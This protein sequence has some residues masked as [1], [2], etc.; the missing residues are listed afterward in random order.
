MRLLKV[1]HVLAGYGKKDII[2]DV[3]MQVERGQM[4]GI[5]GPN[6]CGK[7]TLMKAICKGIPFQGNIWIN[8]KDIRK[9]SEKSLATECA[10]LPQSS[11][12]SFDISALEVVEM[13]FY[14]YL[15]I[16]E[17]PGKEQKDRAE[18]I[19]KQVGLGQY[20]HANYMELS[21]GQKRLCILARCLVADAHLLLMDEPDASLDF[22]IRNQLLQLVE[23]RVKSEKCG[24]LCS[25]HDANLALAYCDTIYLMSEGQIVG[26]IK[27]KEESS[28]EIRQKLS[29]LYGPVQLLCYSL[30]DE[31]KY[32]IVQA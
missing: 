15:G 18:A 1:E 12:I 27:P 3:S 29:L 32:A 16:L 6:G 4:V 10:Y 19:L 9:L 31:Q 11:G 14:P 21:E 7:S 30:K 25:L 17:S 24:L 5:L 20:I 23:K 2:C 22:G 8:Q 28:D 13:G 26:L